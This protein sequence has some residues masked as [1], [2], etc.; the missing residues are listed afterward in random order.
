[1]PTCSRALQRFAIGTVGLCTALSSTALPALAAPASAGQITILS[2]NSAIAALAGVQIAAS[3]SQTEGTESLVEAVRFSYQRDAATAPTEIT[4][5]YSAAAQFTASWTPPAAGTYIEIAE[6]LD[7]SGAVLSR[8]EKNL[9][10][11]STAPS[12]TIEQR[13]FNPV[14]GLSPTGTIRVNGR[15]SSDH[16]T[17]VVSAQIRN[18]STGRISA[19]S[20]SRSIGVAASPEAKAD[21]WV[22]DVPAPSCQNTETSG[23]TYVVTATASSGGET[24]DYVAL[25][26]A[27]VQ[28]ASHVSMSAAHPDSATGMET[29]LMLASVDQEDSAMP[30]AR[31]A[32]SSPSPAAHFGSTAVTT[33]AA[34]KAT[35]TVRTTVRGTIRLVVTL[36]GNSQVTD[37]VV[38]NFKD[39][40]PSRIAFEPSYQWGTI[41][42]TRSSSTPHMRNEYNDLSVPT[43]CLYGPDGYSATNTHSSDLIATRTR[44]TKTGRVTTTEAPVAVTLTEYGDTNHGC[45]ALALTEPGPEDS[46]SD[47]FTVQTSPTSPTTYTQQSVTTKYSELVITAPPVKGLTAADIPVRVSFTTP[48]G[49]GFAGEHIDLEISGGTFSAAQPSNIGHYGS[50][51][52]SC[53]ADAAG[54]CVVNTRRDS[55]GTATLTITDQPNDIE[56]H[57]G[58]ATFVLATTTTTILY[59]Q[60]VAIT[61]PAVVQP[62]YGSTFTLTGTAAPSATVILHFHTAAMKAGVYSLTRS[63]AADNSGRWSLVLTATTDSRYFASAAT[64]STNASGS[65]L[66]Q[67]R[68]TVNG[69]TTRTVTRGAKT[70]IT[71][72]AVPGSTIFLHLNSAG[73]KAG[74]Y[75]TRSVV[76]AANGR[77]SSV[78]TAKSDSRLYVSRAAADPVG[79]NT[80]YL[81]KAR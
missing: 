27:Y 3:I 43:F 24:T 30:G 36:V 16:S 28:R 32:L 77:W 37:G 5:V 69:P 25:G 12:V 67:P 74:E 61:S 23:C 6:A 8:T 52:A 64:D 50:T 70:T 35:T 75:L 19:P 11:S 40:V 33:D 72:T 22:T 17:V 55:A 49:T 47:M 4:T 42:P 41:Y 44:T 21:D 79:A 60:R 34:G 26:A 45:Y 58:P 9:Q 18:N 53:T 73:M 78:F 29:P 14:F 63:V 2:Q 7:A 1:M 81:V 13:P 66:V 80:L 71:G 68:P 15:R 54:V 62:A 10:V 76:T 31:L 20:E 57:D 38:I 46:G 48:D 39:P 51:Y 65:A 59:A 56:D